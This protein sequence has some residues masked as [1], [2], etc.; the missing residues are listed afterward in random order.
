MA[1]AIPQQ[2]C[3]A[4]CQRCCAVHNWIWTWEEQFLGQRRKSKCFQRL[5]ALAVLTGTFS[6]TI[7]SPGYMA[8]HQLYAHHSLVHLMASSIT[9]RRLDG[10]THPV[11]IQLQSLFT[12]QSQDL[13][14]T[15]GPDFQGAQ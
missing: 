4:C 5:V 10:S 3:Q 7:Q 9:I 13:D 2:L 1:Q 8:T 6:H 14:L 12:P 15:P 11:T